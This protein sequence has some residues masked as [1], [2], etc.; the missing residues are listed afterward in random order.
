MALKEFKIT[1]GDVK[2]RLH[3]QLFIVERLAE[4]RHQTIG[5]DHDRDF[6]QEFQLALL[7]AG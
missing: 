4:R 5:P 2:L 7:R 6:L 1:F 3:R